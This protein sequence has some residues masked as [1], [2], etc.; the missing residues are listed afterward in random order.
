MFRAVAAALAVTLVAAVPAVAQDR[1]LIAY[2]E[3]DDDFYVYADGQSAKISSWAPKGFAV[4]GA[5]RPG[6]APAGAAD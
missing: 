5:T 3:S 1:G 6:P 4:G 2:V